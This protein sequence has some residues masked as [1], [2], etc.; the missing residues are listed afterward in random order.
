V[1]NNNAPQGLNKRGLIGDVWVVDKGPAYSLPV[2]RSRGGL[3][4][5]RG[6]EADQGVVQVSQLVSSGT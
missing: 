3:K 6:L 4:P 2:R 5:G 1:L